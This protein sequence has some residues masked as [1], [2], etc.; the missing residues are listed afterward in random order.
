MD[1]YFRKYFSKEEKDE[2]NY[3]DYF[4]LTYY[5][6]KNYR[7]DYLKLVPDSFDDS[8]DE[9]KYHHI[10]DYYLS[11]FSDL[12]KE[13]MLLYLYKTERNCFQYNKGGK[14][15]IAVAFYSSKFNHSCDPSVD[16]ELISE[17][18]VIVFETNR[19]IKAG[20]ELFI[21]YIDNYEKRRTRKT[22]LN[23]SYGF[24]CMCN[25]CKK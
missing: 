1:S 4:N 8:F 25:K 21:T 5:L 7:E 22:Y 14:M 18:D 12:D 15:E 20:E 9:N 11:Y 3:I 6:F 10:K 23:D 16:Y 17:D 13:T 2:Y 24:N 19:D